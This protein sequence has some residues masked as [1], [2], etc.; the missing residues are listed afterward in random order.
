[1]HIWLDLIVREL[2]FLVLLAMLGAGPAALLSDRFEGARAALA[3]VLGLCVGACLAVTMVDYYPA[4]Q[5][6]WL[7]ATVAVVSSAVAAWRRPALRLPSPRSALQGAVVAV[8]ILGAFNYPLAGRHT[9][10][11]VGGYTVAD[12]S[13]YVSEINGLEHDSLRDARRLKS[14]YSDL[15]IVALTNY[16]RGNQQLDIAALEA[17]FN[18]L[19]GLGATD[20][21]SACLI[22]VLLVGALG[23]FGV[24]RTADR[25]AGWAA[26]LAG[27]LYAGPAFT[28]LLMEGSQAAIAGSAV[29]APLVALGLEALRRPGV[30]NLILFGLL[31]AGLQ[32]VYPLFVPCVVIGAGLTLGVA[33]MRSVRAR[34]L[35]PSAVLRAGL[36][37]A[38]VLACAIV[39]TPVAFARNVT[40]WTTIL[41]GNLSFA[42]L[43]QYR[44][45][46]PVAPGWLLQTRDFYGPVNPLTH[47]TAG[48]FALAAALPLILLAVIGM[49]IWRNRAA[50]AMSAVAAGA[51]LL[52]YY[53]WRYEGCG[54]CVQRNL[55]PVAALAPSGLALGLSAVAMLRP[56]GVWI[57]ATVALVA[58]VIIGHEGIVLRQRL[59][60]GDYL[61]DDGARRA[62]AALPTGAGPVNLEGFAEGP[63]AP[64]ELPLVYNLADEKTHGRVSLPTDVDD[65]SGLAYLTTGV[66]P[67]GR[68][69]HYDYQYVLTRVAG[70]RNDRQTVARF[71]SIALQR[72]SRPVDVTV[73]GG[74][75]VPSAR[76]DPSGTAWVNPGLPLAFLILGGSTAQPE[77]LTLGFHASVPVKVDRGPGVVAHRRVGDELRVC[78]RAQGQAPIRSAVVQTV[79]TPTPP[80]PP[81][82]RFD[83]PLPARGLTLESMTVSPRSCA[84][85]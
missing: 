17:T 18:S 72:R 45:P 74:L 26:V 78:V 60:Q 77:W 24:V 65:N 29:L 82:G 12:T 61:L 33:L 36:A 4:S 71:G 57:A 27:C 28:Q 63:Q 34:R 67:L 11:P 5:T 20:T 22:T 42:G 54:Y 1:M 21:Q 47:A 69:F 3:P 85:R 59:S 9:V 58:I 49:G 48:Q 23:A 35:T 8:V 70:V 79:F 53:T 44:I 46:G 64:M 37:L 43:P 2:L 30:A 84:R 19:V 40:Y 41:H 14:S 68:S 15:S 10:G 7:I 13:G 83:A 81:P 31:A 56:P 32:T 39:F 76:L 62:L 80:P 66:L 38:L 16:G 55:I 52:A 50:L 75:S 6:D 73:V 25:R 51:I